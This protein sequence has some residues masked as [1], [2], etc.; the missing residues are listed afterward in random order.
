MKIF[1]GDSS[2]Q[3]NFQVESKDVKKIKNSPLF[4]LFSSVFSRIM[5][6]FKKF[7]LSLAKKE[8]QNQ[9]VLN[10][11]KKLQL[12]SMME[13]HMSFLEELE[14][15][16]KIFADDPKA[17]EK[18]PTIEIAHLTTKNLYLNYKGEYVGC[19]QEAEIFQENCNL[20][21]LEACARKIEEVAKHLKNAAADYFNRQSK[22]LN[23]HVAAPQKNIPEKEIGLDEIKKD[24]EKE[25]EKI[26][27]KIE[28]E[29]DVKIKKAY[30][31]L[32][33]SMNKSLAVI[34]KGMETEENFDPALLSDFFLLVKY[35][36][37]KEGLSMTIHEEVSSIDEI[38][39]KELQ[40][41]ERTRNLE[42]L[43]ND[44]VKKL[45]AAFL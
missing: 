34:Q 1:F 42:L 6:F 12:D 19:L 13:K 23:D 17:I 24:I 40:I 22:A 7:S 15:V 26:E 8:E 18:P 45:Q 33:L 37:I 36:I 4:P 38:F 30:Q 10:F 5:H 31:Y 35:Q 44:W 14:K 21:D 41:E 2:V 16:E 28:K 11:Q 27:G 25:L 32:S 20:L 9:K 39:K 3:D 29:R 43:L